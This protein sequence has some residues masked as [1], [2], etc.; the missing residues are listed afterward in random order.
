[1]DHHGRG[2]Q[3]YPADRPVGSGRTEIPPSN[4]H[5]RLQRR[6]AGRVH[7]ATLRRPHRRPVH[8]TQLRG[9]LR[10]LHRALD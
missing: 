2:E 3:Q 4:L 8:G 9:Q 10:A 7:Q 6:R 1:M 5:R